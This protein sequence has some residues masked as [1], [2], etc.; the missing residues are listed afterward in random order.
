MTM[1]LAHAAETDERLV[2]GLCV[3]CQTVEIARLRA[4]IQSLDGKTI[5]IRC[6]DNTFIDDGIIVADDIIDEQQP[7]PTGT[8]GQ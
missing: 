7:P 1:C 5:A 4:F 6:E 3:V 8:H 2:G